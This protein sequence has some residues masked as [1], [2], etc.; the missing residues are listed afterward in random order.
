MRL[1]SYRVLHDVGL[2]RHPGWVLHLEH[3]TNTLCKHTDTVCCHFQSSH[4][5]AIG[6]A[7][8]M[9][10]H[11]ALCHILHLSHTSKMFWFLNSDGL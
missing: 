1:C 3:H 8:S 9:K 6:T 2:M 5:N 10:D 7:A 11:N 4:A